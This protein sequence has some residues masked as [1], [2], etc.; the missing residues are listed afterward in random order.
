MVNLNWECGHIVY[1]PSPL[2]I[3]E[4]SLPCVKWS[5]VSAEY[6]PLAAPSEIFNPTL[7][8]GSDLPTALGPLHSAFCPRICEF[9]GVWDS[10]PV[11][12]IIRVGHQDERELTNTASSAS[13]RFCFILASPSDGYL[14]NA[15]EPPVTDK[16]INQHPE[17]T[18]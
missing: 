2:G 10:V 8:S 1:I 9:W 6:L 14:L 18:L 7:W 4:F 13:P 11:S 12:S 17:N 3:K 5:T 15:G 16:S